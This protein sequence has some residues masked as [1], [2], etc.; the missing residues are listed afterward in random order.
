MKEQREKKISFVIP[1]YK[2]ALTIR[3]VV[4]EIRET[5][6]DK[7]AYEIILVNDGSNDDTIDV[8]VALCN[9]DYRIKGINL[10][11]NF[12]QHCAIMAGYRHVSGDIIIT[13]DD[14]G[15]TPANESLKLIEAVS[16][17][18][19]AIAR[20]QHKQ[21]S[22]FKNM[23]SRIN[24]YTVRILLNKPK[25][26]Y[27]SSF[28]AAKRFIIDEIVRYKQPYPYLEGLLLRTSL[29]IV[30]VDVCHRSRKYGESTYSFKKLVKLWLDGFTAFSVK[31]LRIASVLGIVLGMSGFIYTVYI[32]IH[33]WL[34]PNVSVGWSSIMA[35]QLV[36][37][38]SILCVLGLIGEYIGR[39]YICINSSP[40]YVIKERFNLERVDE[41]EKKSKEN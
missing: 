16:D 17:H 9:E 15:Q 7:Y 19:M 28:F 41:G 24:D 1:C 8:I 32:V 29:N 33:K 3:E 14:D 5:I 37:G 23:G 26:L 39:I 2:S 34:N 36:I 4:E 11:K 12:G 6:E 22:R 18:D 21:H 27:S 31:P 13:L 38:G 10:T 35:T 20:Y 30:N 25:A 40:Q